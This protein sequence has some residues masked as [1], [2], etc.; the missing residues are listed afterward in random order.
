MRACLLNPKQIFS[1]ISPDLSTIGDKI[2]PVWYHSF[3]SFFVPL[4]NGL[5]QTACFVSIPEAPRTSYWSLPL[6]SPNC[7]DFY[8]NHCLLLPVKHASLSPTPWFILAWILK[9]SVSDFFHSILYLWDSSTV[10]LHSYNSFCIIAVYSFT[11]I[12]DILL[13]FSVCKELQK[14]QS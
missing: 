10:A 9:S 8:D 3:A 6:P 12:Y 1:R 14:T 7:F 5:S 4:L 2:M 11:W 13:L